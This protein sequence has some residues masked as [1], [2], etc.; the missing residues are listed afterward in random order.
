MWLPVASTCSPRA[1]WASGGGAK[2]GLDEAKPLWHLRSPV[3]SGSSPELTDEG[4]APSGVRGMD[5]HI[6]K[7]HATHLEPSTQGQVGSSCSV[8]GKGDQGKEMETYRHEP[9]R[10]WCRERGLWL[11]GSSHL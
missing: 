6:W 9:D 7:G 4:L 5:I 10:L 2:L 11:R 3:V 1:G 8:G